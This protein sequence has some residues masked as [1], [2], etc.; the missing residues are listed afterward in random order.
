MR[1]NSITTKRKLPS[2]GE[3]GKD[4]TLKLTNDE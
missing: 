4:G 2:E 1:C 3:G